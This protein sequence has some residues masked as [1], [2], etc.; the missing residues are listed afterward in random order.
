MFRGGWR[1]I[2]PLQCIGVNIAVIEDARVGLL[3]VSE[4]EID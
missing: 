2:E 3:W 4:H 1:V